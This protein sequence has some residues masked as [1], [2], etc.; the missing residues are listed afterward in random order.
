MILEMHF[1]TYIRIFFGHCHVT[2]PYMKPLFFF[3]GFV[4]TVTVSC[5]SD[6]FVPKTTQQSNGSCNVTSDSQFFLQSIQKLA[7][8]FLQTHMKNILW[9]KNTVLLATMTRCASSPIADI[10]LYQ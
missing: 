4:Q 8:L 10:T 5:F 6:S 2:F 7:S 9:V 1:V 3:G